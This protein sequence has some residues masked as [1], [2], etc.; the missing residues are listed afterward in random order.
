[1]FAKDMFDLSGEIAL[2]TG[3]SSGIGARLAT[4]LAANGAKVALVARREKELGIVAEEI[5]SIGGEALVAP[6]DISMHDGHEQ[7]LDFIES[8]LGVVNTLINNAG[9]ARGSYIFETNKKDW[10]DVMNTNVDPVFFLGKKT[11][12][13]MVKAGI[14]GSIINMASMLGTKTPKGSI[15]YGTSKAAVIHLTK[16]MAVELAEYGIRVNAIAPGY[17]LTD[18]NSKYFA[19]P[20][21]KKSLSNIPLGR[22]GHVSDIDG[23][24]LLLASPIAGSFITGTVI[25]VDGGHGCHF[26]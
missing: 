26:M 18:I 23:I 25:T 20:N 12:S 19:G 22:I 6:F 7:L 3:A 4:V 11:A 24:A 10:D 8:N 21:G 9:I 16:T 2:V 13:R 14:K 1:M 17:I 15:G 5:R